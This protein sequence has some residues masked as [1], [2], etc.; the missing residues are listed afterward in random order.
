MRKLLTAAAL[1]A[2]VALLAACAGPRERLPSNRVIERALVGAPGEAQP[3][4]IVRT[5]LA[6]ARMAREDGQWTAF[7][8]FAAPAG[9]MLHG[10]NGLVP[11]LAVLEGLAD[12]A[13]S[14]QWAPRRVVMSCDGEFAISQGRYLD[15][16]GLV[17]TFITIWQRQPDNEY[18]WIYDGGGPDV[19]QPAPRA[20]DE[21]EGDIVVTAMDLVEGLVAT[22]PGVQMPL[23]PA[24]ATSPVAER[25]S[26]IRQS[27]DGTLRWRT[28]HRTNAEG[29]GEKY[30]VAEYFFEGAWIT[31]IEE[32][33]A[34]SPEG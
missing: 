19:P 2:P 3:S 22:C 23:V 8:E 11:A 24:P 6:F 15:P 4:T 25:P 20:R 27:R 28:Q 21:E 5:E 33:L 12:P 13:S 29:K 10:R 17:G 34:S 32:V 7:R 1:I 26:E 9:A 30:V 31:A 18:R 16:E 14:V